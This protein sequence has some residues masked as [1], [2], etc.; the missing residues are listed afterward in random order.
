MCSFARRWKEI[1]AS[2]NYRERESERVGNLVTVRYSDIKRFK[3]IN[4]NHVANV[5]EKYIDIYN[6]P[7]CCCYIICL[8]SAYITS[9]IICKTHTIFKSSLITFLYPPPAQLCCGLYG[10]VVC[11]L[12]S[13][14]CCL[15]Y[16]AAKGK[17]LIQM[18]IS[19][20]CDPNF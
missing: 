11:A 9:E 16:G 19:K 1:A 15:L 5:N 6:M 12:V 4:K 3:A 13:Y 8:R 7:C 14:L 10:R 18:Q 17:F 2:E 20:I